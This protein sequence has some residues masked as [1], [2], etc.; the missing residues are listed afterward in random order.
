MSKITEEWK[1]VVGYEGLY[2][3]SDW[4]RVRSVDHYVTGRNQYGAEFKVLRRGK[5]RKIFKHCGTNYYFVNLN[6]EGKRHSRDVHR[7]VAETFIPNTE[8]KPCVGH[9]DCDT[10][11]NAVWNLYWCTH[12]ENNN[13]PITRARMS[14]GQRRYFGNGGIPSFKGRQHTEES[15][16]KI[17]ESRKGKLTGEENPMYGKRVEKNLKPCNLYTMDGE[18]IKRFDCAKDVATEIGCAPTNVTACCKGKINS[19]KG[20]R[21]EYAT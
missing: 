3:V 21:V 9:W 19:V 15:R 7:I 17:S 8:N 4:G 1:P 5:I 18:F 14:E 6:F 16:A 2:E 20:F 13:N 12:E 11:N 10:S